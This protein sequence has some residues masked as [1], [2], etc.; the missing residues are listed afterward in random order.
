MKH[1][2]M[3]NAIASINI[4]HQFALAQTAYSVPLI[5]GLHLATLSHSY[6]LKL[7]RCRVHNE[8]MR[9]LQTTRYL[10]DL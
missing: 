1:V 8:G 4:K 5:K 10:L 7:D 6:L 9:V 2:S 3:L